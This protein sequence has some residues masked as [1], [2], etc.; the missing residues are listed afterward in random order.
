MKSLLIANWKMN[1]KTFKEAR[2]LFEATKKAAD[3]AK[4]VT[5]VVAPPSLYLREL[6]SGYRGKRLSFGMQNAHFESKGSFTGELSIVQSKDA[7]ATYV[8]IGHAERRA[9]GETNDETRQKVAAAVN[10]S[11]AAILCVGEAERTHEG[12]YFEFIK[13]QLKAGFA[14]VPLAKLGK[15]II[16]YEPVWAIGATESMNPRDMHEMA[17]FI[18]KTLVELYGEKGMTVRILYGGSIDAEN[19]SAMLTGGD[20]AGLLVGRASTDPA[21]LTELVRAIKNL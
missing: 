5:I 1:P 18:R 12:D 17:I 6:R 15:V 11:M 21:T 14:D 9:M 7:G 16:A 10:G 8:I 13:A 2:A 3:L 4:N 19:A 20:V